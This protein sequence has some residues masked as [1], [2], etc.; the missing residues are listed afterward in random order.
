MAEPR[1]AKQARHPDDGSRTSSSVFPQAPGLHP[2]HAQM[3]TADANAGLPD[4]VTRT[5]DRAGV[6]EPRGQCHCGCR[7]GGR[8][9]EGPG[10][11]R[12]GLVARS[13]ALR[14][15]LMGIW[16]DAVARGREVG[17]VRQ[18]IPFQA[19]QHPG[20]FNQLS[21]RRSKRFVWK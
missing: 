18:E 8:P 1:R 7:G 6:L 12:P 2:A 19:R 3:T 20:S 11:R 4:G 14:R 17:G 9:H 10:G 15:D 5:W 21:L 13:T 16:S